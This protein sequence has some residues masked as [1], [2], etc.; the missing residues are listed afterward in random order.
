VPA[1]VVAL[2]VL[3]AGIVAASLLGGGAE[4]LAVGTPDVLTLDLPAW[5]GGVAV[6]RLGLL[7]A[8]FLALFAG[9]SARFALRPRLAVPLMV[10]ALAGALAL[11]AGTDRAI[12]T[13]PFLA[14][15]FLVPALDRL[16]PLLRSNGH[17]GSQG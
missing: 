5:G 17:E 8:V 12:P 3:V 1:A 14:A 10:C 16:G 6:A 4:P 11:S 9:W 2:P 15:G 7:D 13:L